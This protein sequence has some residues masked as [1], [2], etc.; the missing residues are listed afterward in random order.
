MHLNDNDSIGYDD[1]G[2]YDIFNDIDFENLSDSEIEE[3]IDAV[4]ENLSEEQSAY[5]FDPVCTEDGVYP[6][7]CIADCESVSHQECSEDEIDDYFFGGVDC[8][9]V[10][11]EF[12]TEIELPD[13][14]VVTVN[15]EEE[16]FDILDEWYEENTEWDEEDWYDTIPPYF[17]D[18]NYVYEDCFETI[19]PVDVIYDNGQTTTVGSEDAFYDFLDQWFQNNEPGLDS[20]EFDNFPTIAFPYDVEINATNEVVTLNDVEDY[21]ELYDEECD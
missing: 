15:S 6:S 21:Y 14:S 1:C 2:C 7:A 11:W 10:F 20:L 3:A 5:L 9:S 13:G 12:P 19:Y 8:D 4:F 17:E 18:S 16:L